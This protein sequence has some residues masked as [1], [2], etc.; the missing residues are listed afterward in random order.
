VSLIGGL[1]L[2][3]HLPFCRQRCRYC[4]FIS[5]TGQEHLIPDYRVAL[6]REFLQQ[7]HLWQE[8]RITSIF[9]GGG[10]PSLWPAEELARIL[11][12]VTD[13]GRVNSGAE[14]TLEANPG[15]VSREKLQ[16]LYRA[17]FNRISFGVQ[18]GDDRLL[19]A[20]GR[21]HTRTDAEAAVEMA[22][23][24]GFA[25]LNLDL[26]FGLPGQSLTDWEK[27][28]DWAV[29]LQP[30]HL[31]CYGLQLEEG[32]P[33]AE[34]VKAGLAKLPSE[35]G[36]ADMMEWV[37]DFLPAHGW[38]QYEI[39]NYRRE[40][41]ACRHNLT[42]W[43]RGDYLGLG[44][45]AV[46][47]IGV[48]RW[49]NT[50]SI[51][52]YLNGVTNLG[53]PWREVEYLSDHQVMAE[54]LMLGLRLLE[55]VDKTAFLAQHHVTVESVIGDALDELKQGGWVIDAEGFLRLS[56]KAVIVAN[57]VIGRCCAAL[58]DNPIP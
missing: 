4:D 48:K 49:S 14:I 21:I 56:K 55:G 57:Q 43:R 29:T 31:S 53:A 16:T 15:T 9:F 8:A 50:G 35:D 18:S 27:T 24:A 41:W 7:R 39:S 22:Y 12:T 45:G 23:D 44:A 20:I 38:G 52:D 6:S 34:D 2:Y 5:S 17:G 3:I 51:R 37:M 58:L 47:T 54:R 25:N 42:Y 10:T 13:S 19:Q 33:L 46:S 28:L 30:T 1:A 26:I 40:G 32:T 36:V 11:E